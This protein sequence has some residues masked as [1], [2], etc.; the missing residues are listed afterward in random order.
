MT[1]HTCGQPLTADEVGLSRKLVNRG[2]RVYWCLP[3]LAKDFRVSEEALRDMI[4]RFR[5]SGCTLF[6]RQTTERS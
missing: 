1:C 3:C 6:P 4:E 2:T 5:A